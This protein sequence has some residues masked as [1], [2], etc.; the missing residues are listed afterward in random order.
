MVEADY[1]VRFVRHSKKHYHSVGRLTLAEALEKKDNME[2]WSEARKLAWSRRE[3]NPNAYY[4]R[5]N[6]P[7]EEQATGKWT[8]ELDD[9]FFARL[10][11]WIAEH[12]G[13]MDYK[14]GLFSKAI[15]GKVGYQCSNYYRDMVKQ[16]RVTD[17]NYMWDPK[18]KELRFGFKNKGFERNEDGRL[19][20]NKAAG[21]GG[22]KKRGKKGRRGGDDD[23]D[24]CEYRCKSA[25]A[26]TRT[27]GRNAG[28]RAKYT[29]GSDGEDEDFEEKPVLPGFVDP[30]TQMQVVEP[31]LSPYGHVMGYETWCKILR[32]EGMK[33][34]CPFTRQSLKR[35]QLVKLTHE[36]VEEHRHKICETQELQPMALPAAGSDD[37][38]DEE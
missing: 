20:V 37:D 5:F 9:K 11:E 30:I 24:D 4:Y 29:D 32:T 38:D 2:G 3:T 34:T 15:P 36:N 33:D 17:D 8:K 13:K 16:G 14:W 10:E 35:R 19:C 7:G 21:G 31:A 12:D 28:K 26:G 25:P 23:D 1:G 18:T 27:S 6:D 22:P